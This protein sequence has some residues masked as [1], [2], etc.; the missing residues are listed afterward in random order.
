[1]AFFC[2]VCASIFKRRQTFLNH[3]LTHSKDRPHGCSACSLTFRQ[4]STR[5]RHFSTM[6]QNFRS[7]TLERR[8]YQCIFCDHK[9]YRGAS[10]LL[11]HE[12]IHFDKRPLSCTD[13][14]LRFT[15]RSGLVGHR[16]EKHKTESCVCDECGQ[17][18]KRLAAMPSHLHVHAGILPF[19]CRFCEHRSRQRASLLRHER[20]HAAGSFRHKCS[21][22]GQRFTDRQCQ[23][24]H[25]LGAVSV[26]EN[27]RMCTHSFTWRRNRFSVGNAKSVSILDRS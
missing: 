17:E 13:C 23:K 11:E 14:D 26:D 9:C 4:T 2:D 5:D 21:H 7:S 16:R 25:E 10:D 15:R 20:T 18:L 19:K 8:C 1:M 6:H 24:R 12:R 22:C 3:F 27:T